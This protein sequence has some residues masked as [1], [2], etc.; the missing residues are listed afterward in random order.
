MAID[1]AVKLTN[2]MVKTTKLSTMVKISE[3]YLTPSPSTVAARPAGTAPL[4]PTHDIKNFSFSV[5]LVSI[6]VEKNTAIGRITKNKP[7]VIVIA[8]NQWIRNNSKDR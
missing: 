3:E 8:I 1:F 2:T 4:A 7:N 6:A 5:K